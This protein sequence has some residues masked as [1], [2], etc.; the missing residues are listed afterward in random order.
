MPPEPTDAPVDAPAEVSVILRLLAPA[1]A[2]TVDD[3]HAIVRDISPERID[4]AVASLERAGVL[5]TVA[6]EDLLLTEPARRLEAL[7]L[8]C[9]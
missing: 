8:I 9:V 6:A 5:Q 4:A 3:L 1:E 2:R 7:G